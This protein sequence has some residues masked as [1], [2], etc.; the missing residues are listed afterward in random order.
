[1]ADHPA[2]G[3]IV[4]GFIRRLPVHVC[5]FKR[6]MDANDVEGVRKLVHQLHGSGKSY[7]FAA[8]S[9]HSAAIEEMLLRGAGLTAVMPRIHALLGY[10]EGIEGF[11]V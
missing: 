7:G 2:V 6:L 11:G 5:E 4:A 8:I 10:I 9:E 1:M 3:P